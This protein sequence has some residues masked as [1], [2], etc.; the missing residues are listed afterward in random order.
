MAVL[1]NYLYYTS[2]VTSTAEETVSKVMKI[3]LTTGIRTDHAWGQTFYGLTVAGGKLLSSNYKVQ[4]A[5]IWDVTAG[6]DY[7]ATEAWARDLQGLG[8]TLMATVPGTPPAPPP[9]VEP[10]S[11][12][13]PSGM[14]L[15]TTGAALMAA[16][17]RRR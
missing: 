17:F 8:D 13:E 2:V 5:G 14:L 7:S 6:G 12:P 15:M 3:D 11:T 1:G 4:P 16:G 9:P 10:L